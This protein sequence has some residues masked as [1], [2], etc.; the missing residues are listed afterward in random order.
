MSDQSL[1]GLLI[2][3]LIVSGASLTMSVTQ[4]ALTLRGMTHRATSL[5]ARYSPQQLAK[6]AASVTEPYNRGDADAIYNRLDDA[7][8]LQLGHDKVIASVARL[9]SLWGNVDSATYESFRELPTDGGSPS[10]QLNYSVRLS[11]RDVSSGTLQ[12]NVLDKPDGPSLLGF[13][14][15]SR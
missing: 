2:A 14:L 5:P 8:K 15:I 10:Y 9:K 12:I 7:I 11:G 3:I 13:L 6:I 4:V 1:R